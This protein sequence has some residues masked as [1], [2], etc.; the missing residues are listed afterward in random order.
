LWQLRSRH[1]RQ[2]ERE[3]ESLQAQ[4]QRIGLDSAN[5]GMTEVPSS[6]LIQRL[7]QEAGAVNRSVT[8]T[9][10]GRR[11]SSESAETLRKVAL[12]IARLKV[13]ADEYAHS[14]AQR[15]EKLQ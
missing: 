2:I 9:S 8:T 14:V 10:A 11:Q 15:L 3:I 4:F 7:V 1:A 13:L 5:D 6:S 12:E